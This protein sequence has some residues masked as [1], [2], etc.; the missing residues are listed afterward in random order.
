MSITKHLNVFSLV[1]V[2][3]VSLNP[4]FTLG[5]PCTAL[6]ADSMCYFNVASVAG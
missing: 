5:T 4:I 3:L 2:A 6:V 1:I